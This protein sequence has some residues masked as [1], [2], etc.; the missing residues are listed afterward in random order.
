MPLAV[1]RGDLVRR[2]G[3][4]AAPDTPGDSARDAVHGRADWH[5]NNQQ[6]RF[7]VPVRR[8]A[9]REARRHRL[10]DVAARLQLVEIGAREGR[11]TALVVIDA[12]NHGTA[13]A[14]GQA[15]GSFGQ[16]HARPPCAPAGRLELQGLRLE[17]AGFRPAPDRLQGIKHLI[18]HALCRHN[19]SLADNFH[20]AK[21]LEIVEQTRSGCVWCCGTA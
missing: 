3:K 4:A 8:H 6:P 1:Q 2:Q 17:I 19:F 16:H 13:V 10:E 12:E 20:Q 18:R 11:F 21:I 15:R 9:H 7:V 5:L 14:V